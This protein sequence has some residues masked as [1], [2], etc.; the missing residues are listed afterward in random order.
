MDPYNRRLEKSIGQYD[1]T[2]NLKL[3]AVWDLP[4]GKGKP[5]MNI[6]GPANW[7][8][9][10]WRVSG[11]GVYSTG[12]PNS[13]GTTNSIPLFGG[14]LRPIVSTYD[15]WQ[16]ATKG[17]SFDPA[18]QLLSGSAREHFREHDAVQPEVPGIPEPQREPLALE[19]VR[20]PREG[21]DRL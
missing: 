16:P 20:G 17:G 19:V 18:G 4:F 10:G 3:S 11:I 6:G 8:L 2:H 14:G 15:G 13:L 1:V 9:G 21:P 5:L 12:L 7:I